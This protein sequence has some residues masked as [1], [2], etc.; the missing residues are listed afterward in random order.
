M[1]DGGLHRGLLS[2]AYVTAHTQDVVNTANAH[3]EAL[4]VPGV[5]ASGGLMREDGS[6]LMH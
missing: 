5:S 3:T 4:C 6:A 2:D 1:T